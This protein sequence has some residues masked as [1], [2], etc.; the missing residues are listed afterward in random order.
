MNY[1]Q[2]SEAAQQRAVKR[3]SQQRGEWWDSNDYSHVN[4]DAAKV[5]MLLGIEIDT[6]R[7]GALEVE[8]SGFWSQGDGLVFAGTW[9][10]D[11]MQ[12]GRLIDEYPVSSEH[13]RESNEELHRAAALLTGV[14]LHHPLA[15]VCVCLRRYG[16][17]MRS[18]DINWAYT[19]NAYDPNIDD[20]EELAEVHREAVMEVFKLLA[21][22]WYEQLESE[23]EYHVSDEQTIEDIRAQDME[24]DEDGDEL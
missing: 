24:F 4:E 20:D 9:R 10:A 17:G 15:A 16:V 21:D 18:M 5:C 14:R 19:N 12:A 8:W 22:W 6:N 1:D 7:K 3:R 23:Y 11:N 2:L 13:E